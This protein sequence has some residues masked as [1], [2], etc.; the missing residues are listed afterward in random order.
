MP[1]DLSGGLPD[2]YSWRWVREGVGVEEWEEGKGGEPPSL[3]RESESVCF[4]S[5]YG[6]W[7]LS[8]HTESVRVAMQ[9]R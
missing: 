5:L 8:H 7:T 9:V 2:W 3:E 6:L 4:K 1:L